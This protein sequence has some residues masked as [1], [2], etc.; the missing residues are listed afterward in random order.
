M[1]KYPSVQAHARMAP[2]AEALR[3]TIVMRAHLF[4]SGDMGTLNVADVEVPSVVVSDVP[5]E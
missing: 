4:M 5:V 3:V 2:L 1:P